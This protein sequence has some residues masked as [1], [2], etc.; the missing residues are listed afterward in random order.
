MAMQ[1]V[2]FSASDKVTASPRIVRGDVVW[3]LFSGAMGLDLGMEAV[4]LP[5]S[6]AVEIDASC[7]ATIRRNRGDSVV[8]I[9]QDIRNVSGA[10]LRRRTGFDGDV[11]VIVGGPP[12]QAFSPGGNREALA[13]PRGDLVH[14]FFRIV[15]DI[16]PRV[17]VFENVAN[18]ATAAIRHRRIKDRPGQHWSLKSYD[19]NRT[20]KGRAGR[21]NHDARPMDD[22]ELAGSA[23]RLLLNAIRPLGYGI[24]FAV[25]DAADYGAPQHRLRFIMLGAR[26]GAPPRLPH[27]THGPR[28][29]GLAPWVTLR[30]V[31][32]DL[33]ENP[34]HHYVYTAEFQNYFNLVSPGG[35]WRDMPVE[36]QKRAL[37]N[38]FHA[39]GGKTGFFRRLSWDAPSPTITGKPNRKGAALCHP[40]AIRPLSVRECA[41][42][43]GFPDDWVLTGTSEAQYRQIGNAVPTHL[44]TA[45]G[46][47]LLR[48]EVASDAD[49]DPLKLYA[50]ALSRVRA[51]GRNR[52][53]RDDAADAPRQGVLPLL[54]GKHG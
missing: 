33:R 52:Q 31:I 38:A 23:L 37:G 3:S 12:C 36:I 15:S 47:A 39:G 30:D 21:G 17:F 5:A 24:T 11:G 18:L 44:G 9:E 32:W 13:D 27:P 16:R 48:D 26:D 40:E 28:G 2:S 46:H 49:L 51:A 35:H 53:G 6:L 4:G 41:R 8:V 50:R 34:G 42:I 1:A 43:Q 10:D 14:E 22:T 20:L 54:G 45:I 29:S 7:C 19:G 25:L